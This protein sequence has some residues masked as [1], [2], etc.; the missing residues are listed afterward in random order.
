M[1]RMV[2]EALFML[3]LAAF[4]GEILSVEGNSVRIL[5]L[6][7]KNITIIEDNKVFTN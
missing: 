2:M 5:R 6:N 3:E 4:T 7:G 1:V